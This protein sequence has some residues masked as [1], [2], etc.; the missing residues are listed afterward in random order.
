MKDLGNTENPGN[1]ES[2]GNA[3]EN[4][5]DVEALLRLGDPVRFEA[6]DVVNSPMADRVRAR[7]LGQVGADEPGRRPQRRVPVVRL[8]GLVAAVFL[9][10]GAAWTWRREPTNPVSVTCFEQAHLDS[11]RAVPTVTG[12]LDP[13]QCEEV[14]SSGLLSNPDV[15][16]VGEVPV[17]RACVSSSGILFVFPSEQFGLCNALGL[18][19]FERVNNSETQVEGRDIQEVLDRVFSNTS[20]PDFRLSDVRLRTALADYPDW[21]V[22][23]V[24]SPT[25]ERPCAGYAADFENK[26]IRL[27][28]EPTRS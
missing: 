12:T 2:S 13:S 6:H 26:V 10:A 19:G 25:Q 28:P 23:Y 1:G 4:D 3:R 17:F 7:A 9:V 18:A 16:E 27:V 11:S 24:G 21:K 20:C 22:S 8:A 14:W 15:A 5:S